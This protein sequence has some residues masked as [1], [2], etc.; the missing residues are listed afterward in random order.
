MRVAVL[1]DIHSN[2]V[3]LDAVL[4]HAGPVDA[5][6]HLGDVVG[7]GPDPDGVVARLIE[8]GAVGVRGNHDAAAL[9]GAEIE[10]F[11]PEARAGDGVDP[12]RRSPRRRASLARGAARAP[13]RAATFTLVHGSPRDPIWEYVTSPRSP[14]ANLAVLDTPHRPPRPHP[15]ADRRSSWQR[16]PA[17]RRRAR[18]RRRRL[19]LGGRRALAQ[20]GQ[21]R[22]AARRRSRRRATSSSTRTAATR[23][24][25]PGRLR[26][27]R[28]PGA[29]CAPPACR[30]GSPTGWRRPVSED[31]AMIGGRRPL[32]GRKPGD[33]RVRVERPHAPYFRY[34]GPGPARPPR[35]PPARPTTP[36]RPLMR[37]DP[38]RSFSAGRSRQRGG[39]RRAAVEEEGAG[40]LQLGRDQLVGLRD[41][42]DPARS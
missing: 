25:A 36:D 39:D 24:L 6:W 30:R 13:R 28:G 9:G 35:R 33:R 11:N 12:R 34:T 22:P 18:R 19:E 15:R 41:R 31:A 29:R 26:H 3:A 23:D 32:Q 10:W 42:G 21:R 17:S 8:V 7:Y 37:P 40:D 2:L 14:R 4:A 1:S 5:V 38:R 20:P 27:R 16:R